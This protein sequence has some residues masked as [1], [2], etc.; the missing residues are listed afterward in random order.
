AIAAHSKALEVYTED[1]NALR[2][3]RVQQY[4]G[5]ALRERAPS[6]TRKAEVYQRAIS[7]YSTALAILGRKFGPEV[8]AEVQDRLG[9]VLEHVTA[10]KTREEAPVW[11]GQAAEA[12]GAAAS[13]FERKQEVIP[14]AIAWN[15]RGAALRQIGAR[16]GTS[17]GWEQAQSDA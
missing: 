6:S 14:A 1:E 4:L 11:F 17:G 3:A 2:H 10:G 7:A 16:G 12:F 15:R 5:D 8:I 13:G 9:D